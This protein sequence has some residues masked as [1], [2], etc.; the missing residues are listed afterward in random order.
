MGYYKI[1]GLKKEPFSA[2]PDPEF[3]YQSRQHKAVF[4]RLRVAFQLRRGLSVVLG[5]PGLGKTTLI[6]TL[7]SNLTKDNNYIVKNILDP[8]AY[9]EEEFLTLLI[10]C[11][12]IRMPRKYNPNEY[13][14]AIERYLF[15]Y[16]L[17]RDKTIILFI[18]E[19]QKLSLTAIEILRMLLNYETN[20]HKLLQI[21]L[22]GQMELLAKITSLKNFWDRIA[23]QYI[24]NPLDKEEIKQ[25][26]EFRLKQ[27]GFNQAYLL[28]NDQAIDLIYKYTKGYIRRVAMC[29]HNAMQYLIMHDREYIDR[30]VIAKVIEWE[31]NSEEVKDTVTYNKHYENL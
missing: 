15:H 20:D 10:N 23:L 3:F 11:F 25:L 8:S 28:F 16:G 12:G 22:V 1:L 27:A 2:S 4:F 19:A 13:K 18:D 5:Q 29:C 24:L 7:F 17:K 31:L 6:R 14:K 26:I 9:T 30:E 21:V